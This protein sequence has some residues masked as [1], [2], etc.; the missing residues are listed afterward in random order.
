VGLIFAWFGV[1]KF[2][3][4]VSAAESLATDTL[5]ILTLGAIPDRTL[6]LLLAIYETALGVWLL[7]GRRARWAIAFLWM[8]MAGTALPLLFFPAQLFTRVPYAPT[9][10]G[11]YI[12]KNLVIAAAAL[13]VWHEAGDRRAGRRAGNEARGSA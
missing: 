8:H 4:G 10:E 13:V 11:Q 6:L 3:P 9:L 5:K 2:F 7:S 12:L 1:L